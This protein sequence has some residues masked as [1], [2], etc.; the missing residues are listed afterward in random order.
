MTLHWNFLEIIFWS[1]W[2]FIIHFFRLSVHYFVG[3]SISGLSPCFQKSFYI[4]VFLSCTYLQLKK[5]LSIYKCLNVQKRESKVWN[6][7]F[8]IL[9]IH[10]RFFFKLIDCIYF[11]AFAVFE[12]TKIFTV[13]FF[14]KIKKGDMFLTYLI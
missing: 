2:G 9:Q 14:L 1:G 5:L 6:I 11:S 10:F 13:S 7:V 3:F 4:Y 8:G 12:S